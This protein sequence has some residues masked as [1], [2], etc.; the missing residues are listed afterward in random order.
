MHGSLPERETFL[1]KRER[2]VSEMHESLPDME[3]SL[4]KRKRPFYKRDERIRRARL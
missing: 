4:L 3:T 1:L 2:P